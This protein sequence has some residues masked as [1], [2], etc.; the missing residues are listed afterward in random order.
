MTQ[1]GPTFNRSTLKSLGRARACE[2]MIASLSSDGRFTGT[3]IKAYLLH[4]ISMYKLRVFVSCLQDISIIKLI[5]K[6]PT[7]TEPV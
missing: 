2:R 7:S 1:I 6:S 4:G 3:E 5:M